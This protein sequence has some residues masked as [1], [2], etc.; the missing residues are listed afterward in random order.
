MRAMHP[1]VTWQYVRMTEQGGGLAARHGD[2]GAG[3]EA[4]TVG[5]RDSVF[6]PYASEAAR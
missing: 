5:R 6:R 2:T 3:P 1:P 4:G